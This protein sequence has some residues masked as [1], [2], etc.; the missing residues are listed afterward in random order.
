MT[1]G[2]TVVIAIIPVGSL[3]GA[4]SRL[5]AVL[6]AEE[7]RDLAEAFTRRTIRAALATP[8]ITETLVI[9]PDDA[10]RRLAMALGARPLRQRSS[11]LNDGLREARDEAIAAG[12]E[13]IIVLPTDLPDI[14]PD[15]IGLV[16]SVLHERTGP[17]VAIV[18]DRHERGTNALLLSPP[19]VIDFCFGGDSHDAHLGA[20]RA[21]GAFVVELASPLD[22]DVDTA[23][24][25]VLAQTAHPE[26]VRG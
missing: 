6:D 25:L 4:K 13:A 5:G 12:A 19:D 1:G 18:A 2:T 7:R 17:V 15:A 22:L 21:A 26:R 11:G 16:M 23:E 14:S 8:G 3:E 20:A 24:D 9:T 10:V